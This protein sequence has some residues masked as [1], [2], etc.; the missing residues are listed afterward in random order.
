MLIDSF[1]HIALKRNDIVYEEGALGC[2]FYIVISGKLDFW[3]EG[4]RLKSVTKGD[5]FGEVA[6]IDLAP[7]T[8]TVYCNPAKPAELWSLSKTTYKKVNINANKN[9]YAENK[10]FIDS[11]PL[12]HK[13]S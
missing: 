11:I 1:E 12:F 13:L 7:R 9:Y 8:A 5:I 2:N 4:N 3:A 10:T 6:L